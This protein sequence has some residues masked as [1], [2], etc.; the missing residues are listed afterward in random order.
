MWELGRSLIRLC[1]CILDTLMQLF[2]FFDWA[3]G[4][5]GY[6]TAALI[7]RKVH[8]RKKSE[9]HDWRECSEIQDALPKA[10]KPEGGR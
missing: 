4:C 1:K 9:Q 7:K 2:Y 5:L 8:I 3:C 6:A 10:C